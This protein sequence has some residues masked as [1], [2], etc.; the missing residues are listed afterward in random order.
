[1]WKTLRTKRAKLGMLSDTTVFMS[2]STL[3]QRILIHRLYTGTNAQP[4]EK[5]LKSFLM[6]GKKKAL[7]MTIEKK[8]TSKNIISNIIFIILHKLRIKFCC[9][10]KILLEWRT[11]KKLLGDYLKNY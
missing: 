4:S 5:Q 10:I 6:I 9:N 3:S 1:M 11:L 2:T 8:K 7:F